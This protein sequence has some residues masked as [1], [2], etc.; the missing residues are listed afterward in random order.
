MSTAELVGAQINNLK[1]IKNKSLRKTEKQTN[2][3]PKR[4]VGYISMI[5]SNRATRNFPN[6]P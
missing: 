2:Q 5:S 3:Y 1:T 6:G 4:Q